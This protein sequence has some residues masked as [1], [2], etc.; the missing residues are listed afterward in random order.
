MKKTTA[1]VLAALLLCCLPAAYALSFQSDYEA[2]DRAAQSVFLLEVYDGKDQLLATGSGFVAL[3]SGILITNHHVIEGGAYLVAHSDGYKDAYDI[4]Y[5]V[6]AD[7]AKDIAILEFDALAGVQPLPVNVRSRLMRGQPVTAIGSPQGVINTVSSGN[8]SNMVEWDLGI[9]ERIQFTAPIS[10]GS[11][12]GALFN[13]NGEVIGLCTSALVEGDAMYYAVP[14][15]YVQALYEAADANRKI[16][17]YVYNGLDP[18]AFA[19]RAAEGMELPEDALLYEEEDCSED[20]SMFKIR[21]FDL[22]YWSAADEYGDEYT[23]ELTAAVMHFQQ[24]NRIA[25]TGQL[26]VKTVI[27]LLGERAVEHPTLATAKLFGM[28]HTA[29]E[30]GGYS[31]RAYVPNDSGEEVLRLKQRLQKLGYY[32]WDEELNDTFD[33]AMAGQVAQFQTNNGLVDYGFV[34]YPTLIK[35]HSAAAVTGPWQIVLPPEAAPQPEKAV[36]LE[37]PDDGLYEKK[38]G[39][40]NTL[41]IRLQV[42]NTSPARTV[43]A[44]ELKVY[45]INAKGQRMFVLGGCYTLT[46]STDL[47]PGIT[48]YTP[49]VIM[50]NG[51]KIAGVEAGVYKVEYDDGTVETVAEP[52]YAYWSVE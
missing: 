14:M 40:G 38:Y 28:Y 5:L 11:S 47:K 48:G 51:D 50:N 44:Y 19:L 20:I 15:K 27:R 49:F 29:T 22:G 30:V 10:P 23:P 17:L 18:A 4:G 42:K 34:D 16:P 3:H 7:P 46:G 8:I 1:A 43:T 2:I 25:A 37:I 6:A 21:L 33:G 35:L 36:A 41:C 24:E 26:D 45:P 31:K 32:P 13:E 9:G 12:G 39:S 52:E